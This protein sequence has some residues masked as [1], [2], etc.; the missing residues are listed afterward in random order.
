MQGPLAA[1]APGNVAATPPAVKKRVQIAPD[2]KPDGDRKTAKPLPLV[3]S[4]MLKAGE[5]HHEGWQEAAAAGVVPVPAML[6]QINHAHVLKV[7]E[8]GRGQFGT[9]LLARWLGVEV[10]VKQLLQSGDEKASAELL[11]EAEL[12]ASL[13]HPCITQVYGVMLGP[14]GLATVME[15]VRGGSLRNCLQ[16]IKAKGSCPATLKCAIA[17][18]AARGL[19]Y[20][21]TRHVVHFDV[22]AENLLADLHDHEYPVI[23]IADMGLSKRSAATTVSGNMRGTLPWMAPELFPTDCNADGEG[24][25]VTDKVDVFSFGMVMWEIWTL[26][27]MPYT[28]MKM[29]QIFAGVASGMLRPKPLTDAPSEWTAIM[30][31]CWTVDAAERPSFSQVATRLSN[32]LASLRQATGHP[33]LQS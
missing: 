27:G 15:F 18:K 28:G 23:K 3:G 1:V 11:R 20:L 17:L 4:D 24:D 21:H 25:R 22:K 32:L 13:C 19:E 10:A 8:L 5:W 14:E 9:V 16:Q 31:D 12:L 33:L 29:P 30:E 2:A 26:G 6:Q 7:K